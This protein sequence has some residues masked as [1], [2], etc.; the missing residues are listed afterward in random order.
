M[1]AVYRVRD[2]NYL[3]AMMYFRVFIL[4]IVVAA[5][6]NSQKTNLVG[7]KHK[8]VVVGEKVSNGSR[9]LGGS[10]LADWN[11]GVSQYARGKSRMLWLEQIIS[12]DGAGRPT[13]EVKDVLYLDRI[14]KNEQLLLPYGSVCRQNGEDN[15][16]LIVIAE[17]SDKLQKLMVLKAWS[18]DL[19]HTAFKTEPVDA[20]ECD[21]TEL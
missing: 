6:A 5:T 13:W 21:V 19:A 3:E 11:F 9:D 1:L 7:Y 10:L 8:G 16:N 15:L 12:R 17:F 4:I 2:S 18:A 14:K 20:I